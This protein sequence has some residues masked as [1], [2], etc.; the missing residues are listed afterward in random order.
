MSTAPTAAA[1]VPTAPELMSWVQRQSVAP[2][3]AQPFV[4]VSM[5]APTQSVSQSTSLEFNFH[6]NPEENRRMVREELDRAGVVR[7]SDLDHAAASTVA[8]E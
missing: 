8:T 1:G 7:A 3:S 4:A 6:G 5:P 2:E